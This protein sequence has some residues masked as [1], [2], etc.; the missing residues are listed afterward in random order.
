M[1]KAKK[2]LSK[3]AKTALKLL[4]ESKLTPK[5]KAEG[6][7]AQEFK[8]GNSTPKPTPAIKQRPQKKRG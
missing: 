1:P 5:I 6:D 4:E 7:M 2:K 3:N 8:P